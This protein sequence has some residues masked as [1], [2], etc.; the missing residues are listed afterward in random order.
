VSKVPDDAWRK[1]R[2]LINSG[3]IASLFDGQ[4]EILYPPVA[5]KFHFLPWERRE[6]RFV[7]LGRLHEIKRIVPIIR[8]LEAVHRLPDVPSFEVVFV[9]QYNCSH[10]YR[11]EID[12]LVAG[13]DWMR[14]RHDMDRA[15]LSALLS[16]E[17][18]GMAVAEMQE[19]GMIV[20][21]PN[22]GGPREILSYDHRRLYDSDDDAVAKI[23]AVLQAPMR[24]HEIHKTVLAET[25]R[26]L[27]VTFCRSFLQ[28]VALCLADQTMRPATA[29][30][31]AAEN[32]T[33]K[34]DR[35]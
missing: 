32:A 20:F 35:Y 17:H 13:C 6:N 19:A 26:F 2:S 5:G 1:N 24:Q 15:A 33:I 8:I 29:A 34:P 23:A 12:A 16:S 10:Q 18:F 14:L 11:R 7:V 9:G 21:A 3:Y 30:V 22:S 28:S 4:S 25:G 27:L 31:V